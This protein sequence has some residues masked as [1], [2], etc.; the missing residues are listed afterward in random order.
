M[1]PFFIRLIP[2]IIYI[3]PQF[4]FLFRYIIE[5]IFQPSFPFFLNF[6]ESEILRKIR[7]FFVHCDTPKNLG[8]SSTLETLNVENDNNLEN[9]DSDYVNSEEEDALDDLIFGQVTAE[10]IQEQPRIESPLEGATAATPPQDF[11]SGGAANNVFDSNFLEE[12]LTSSD[13]FD[14]GA[15]SRN[16]INYYDDL[17]FNLQLQFY[18]LPSFNEIYKETYETLNCPSQ[19]L[20]V[21]QEF[22]E[23][24]HSSEQ[25]KKISNF[26][27]NSLEKF[28]YSTELC[29]YNNSLTTP[30]SSS[31]AFWD[32]SPVSNS[33]TVSH[34]Y[35][36]LSRFS[37]TN[38]LLHL[39]NLDKEFLLST[40]A[41]HEI[42][43]NFTRSAEVLNT[44]SNDL[45]TL[46][47]VKETSELLEEENLNMSIKSLENFKPF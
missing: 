13:C 39:N 47:E 38:D 46:L 25:N 29:D 37:T 24:S 18:N 44:S 45:N 21:L 31:E 23:T 20:S 26:S 15:I 16:P 30:F 4:I 7:F 40:T 43:L 42:P 2:V 14:S 8:D 27:F 9:D 10:P 12:P 1:P 5:F 35:A 6:I 22:G 19:N 3:S 28:T 41:N 32:L 11:Y 36:I 33:D 34:D 17:K